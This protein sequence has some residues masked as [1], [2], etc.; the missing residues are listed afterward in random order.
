MNDAFASPIRKSIYES[1]STFP[2]IHFR[3][4]I[5]SCNVS[6]GQLS[7]HLS[8]L[9]KVGLIKEEKQGRNSRFYPLGLSSEERAMLGILRNPTS[10]SIIISLL[11]KS[12]QTHKELS[13]Q[14]DMSL[15][16]LSWHLEQLKS[17]NILLMQKKGKENFY[18]LK[19]STQASKTLI[20]HRQSFL[21]KL[22]DNFIE[23]WEK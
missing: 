6:T 5:R 2:G 18:S 7:H 15:S 11:K 16:T 14:F 10:R 22:V 12:P 3:E 20:A 8:H 13:S 19:D 4:L 9:K 17:K 1:I 23:S 21:D